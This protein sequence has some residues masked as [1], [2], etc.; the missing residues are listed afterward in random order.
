MNSNLRPHFVI[1]RVKGVSF[2]SDTS[3]EDF[4]KACGGGEP[5]G[6]TGGTAPPDT[7]MKIE[8]F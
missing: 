1:L 8:C 2:G 3:W 7:G 4:E 6:G 5:G